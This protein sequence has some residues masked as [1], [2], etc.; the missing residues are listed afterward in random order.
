M[1]HGPLGLRLCGGEGGGDPGHTGAESGW[2]TL[3]LCET[4]YLQGV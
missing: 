1:E 3:S 2:L 4:D